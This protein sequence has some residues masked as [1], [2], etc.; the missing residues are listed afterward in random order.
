M[1]TGAHPQASLFSPLLPP[2]QA[3]LLPTCK[4]LGIGVL[5]YSPLSRGL[6]AGRFASA[7]DIP[8]GDFRRSALPRFRGDS[9]AKA[10]GRR[11]LTAGAALCRAVPRHAMQR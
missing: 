5:A 4:E 2:P 7:D 6:L 3:D 9:F 11:R 10:S 8:E 1:G